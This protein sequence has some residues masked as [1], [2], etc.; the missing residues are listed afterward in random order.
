MKRRS[1][2][3]ELEDRW[4]AVLPTVCVRWCVVW[5]RCC[6]EDSGIPELQND[7]IERQNLEL[8]ITNLCDQ[9]T[10]CYIIF[11]K[12]IKHIRNLVFVIIVLLFLP[13]RGLNFTQKMEAEPVWSP[14]ICTLSTPVRF[15]QKK[16][17]LCFCDTWH[18]TPVT[19][20]LKLC[21]GREV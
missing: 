1:A 9:E 10:S 3:P 12:F 16:L 14:L 15:P 6:K 20:L 8:G 4:G 19:S 21:V 2:V 13:S 7:V 18:W 5:G 11:L 17:T